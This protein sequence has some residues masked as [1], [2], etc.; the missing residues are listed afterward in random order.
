MS[1]RRT[2]S[3]AQARRLVLRAQGLDRGRPTGRIDRRH[4]RRVIDELGLIQIDSVNVLAR[5][6]YLTLFSRLGPYDTSVFDRV[7]YEDRDAF[8]YWGH[9]ASLVATR[10]QPHLRWRM[11]DDHAWGSLARIGVEHPDLVAALEAEILSSGPWSAGELDDS[12]QRKG[13]WWGWGDTKRALEH[14]FWAGRVG[15]LRRGNFERM[16]CA[17]DLAVP[18]EVLDL[19]DPDPEESHRVLLLHAARMHGVGTARDLADVWRHPIRLARRV[20]DDLVAEGSLHAVEVEGWKDPAFLSPDV[21]L[22]RRADA[23]ALVSPFDSVMWE[24]DR[25]ERLFDFH[26][27]IEIYVPKPKRV[28]GYYVLPFLLGDTYV[29][30]VDLKSDRPGRRLLVQSAHAEPD[31]DQRGTDELE[32]A[33]RLHG[34]LISMAG[35]LGLDGVD[36]VGPGDLAPALAA[37]AAT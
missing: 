20:L 10:L 14:L 28:H 31:L 7:V 26:Y 21:T 23:C 15:A 19:S 29:A 36:I 30:R 16:Y 8:E 35:W 5:T 6:Q 33:E 13:P 4:I 2:L 11:R 32:V 17:P 3:A 9:V 37:V 22:P 12:D 1:G 34:E 27:R 18:R 24:R 25:I